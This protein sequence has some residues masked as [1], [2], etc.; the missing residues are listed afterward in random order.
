MPAQLTP[1]THGA[2]PLAEPTPAEMYSTLAHELRSPLSTVAG[3]L[4]LLANDGVGP[5]TEAQRDFLAVISRNIH[6][7][8]LVVDD[9][10]ELTRLEAGKVAVIRRPVDVGTVAASVLAEFSESIETKQQHCTAELPDEPV[11]ILADARTIRRI[12]TN[13][14]S[15]AHT[16]TQPGGTIR[17]IVGPEGDDGVRIDVID[18]GIGIREEDQALLFRKFFRVPLTESAPGTGLGLTLSKMMVDRL[19]GTIGVQSALGKGAT[20]T[21]R[22]P[23]AAGAALRGQATPDADTPLAEACVPSCS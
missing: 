3:Y 20:F 7:L 19:G 16:Y 4:E 6:R 9:W 18:S 1:D 5:I 8:T 11:W 21:V 12:V 10:L 15:N 14:L 13:L 17:L 2:G 23:R 22:L